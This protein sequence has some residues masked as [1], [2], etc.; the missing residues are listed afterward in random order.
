MTR[1]VN[2]PVFKISILHFI[3][4]D[5]KKAGKCLLQLVRDPLFNSSVY[6]EDI[7]KGEHPTAGQ[8]SIR[9]DQQNTARLL[10]PPV[11]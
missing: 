4:L 6:L 7:S 11:P 1:P 8:S 2:P 10:I 5:T 9:K 3:S